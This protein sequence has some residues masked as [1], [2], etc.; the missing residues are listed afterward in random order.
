MSITNKRPYKSASRK[1][2]AAHTKERILKASKKLFTKE[3]FEHVTIE[4]I[5]QVSEVSVPTVYAL[6]KS[7]RGILR[8]LMDNVFPKEQFD[9]L[10]ARSKNALS[11]QERLS[12]SAKIAREI[13]D[14]EKDQMSL[15]RGATVLSPEFKKLEKEREIRRHSRLEVTMKAM[16]QEKSLNPI[17]SEKK[18][19]DVL[20]A[21]TGRDLY[22]M[23]VMEQGWTSDQYESWLSQMLVDTLLDKKWKEKCK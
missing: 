13:Y 10:V 15:F 2:K 23:L 6:Y 17:L 1:A 16:I 19:H 8:A 21:L 9:A 20:W 3:G 12:Y 4:K 18:S 11:P 7:K 22:R 5:A 14:A